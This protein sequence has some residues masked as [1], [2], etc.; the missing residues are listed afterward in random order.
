MKHDELNQ[1]IDQAGP[2]ML[3]DLERLVNQNSG[4]TNYQGVERVI[5]ACRGILT[6]LGFSCTKKARPG[7]VVNLVARGPK[8]RGVR[9]LAL[10][11]ADTVFP[12]EE[13]QRF[14]RSLGKKCY[15]PGVFDMKGGLI[16]LFYALKALKAKIGYPNRINVLINGDEERSSQF[17]QPLIEAE[18]RRADL[19]LVM[20]PALGRWTVATERSGTAR[21]LLSVTGRA[22]HV[23]RD[24][25]KGVSAI[26]E[27]AHKV[28]A[29]EGLNDFPKGIHVN[30]GL[31]Q[32][33]IARN[34]VP[35]RAEAAIDVRF[36]HESDA[37]QVLAAIEEI[38]ART[39]LPGTRTRLAGGY[40]RPPLETSP[41]GRQFFQLAK[42][43][44]AR[45]GWR[46]KQGRTGGAS[47]GNFAARLGLPTLD[48][49]GP[50]GAHAHSEKEFIITESL[51]ERAKLI[52]QILA[53]DFG[54]L[55]T[56]K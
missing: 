24:P 13:P 52:G 37:E 31:I 39:F 1:Y 8:S 38:A 11:H 46:L 49:L 41:G 7:Q 50:A 40:R 4:S 5:D 42:K 54:S 53:A 36:R 3:A 18:A 9:I 25:E 34:V 48:G 28:I 45:N 21:Y 51:F 22:A 29:L 30:S 17:S 55:L 19:V 47:D 27:M 44:A 35:P 33:G 16:A 20:E 56:E 15:G 6:P 23:G 14:F 32:G 12:P 2:A 43:I 10:G 26:R